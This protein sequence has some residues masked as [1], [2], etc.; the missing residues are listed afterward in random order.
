METKSP[1]SENGVKWISS[2]DGN[3]EIEEITK[4]DRGT[5][6]TLHLKDGDEYNEFLE[7]WKIK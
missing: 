3:Y 1:Y 4:Q 7:D 6:I 5:K 2:G